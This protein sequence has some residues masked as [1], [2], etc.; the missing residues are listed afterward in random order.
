MVQNFHADD[1]NGSPHYTVPRA[2]HQKN[3][4]DSEHE[5]DGNLEADV[6]GALP[7]AEGGAEEILLKNDVYNVLWA[8]LHAD[9][10][11]EAEEIPGQW[12]LDSVLN[13]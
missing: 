11:N 1:H 9:T 7:A 8:M 2:K 5:K 13:N 6:E 12:D 4:S 10:E 3:M